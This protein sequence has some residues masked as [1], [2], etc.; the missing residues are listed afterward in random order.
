MCLQVDQTGELILSSCI[1]PIAMNSGL[2]IFKFNSNGQLYSPILDKC[3][4]V[5]SSNDIID[6]TNNGMGELVMMGDCTEYLDK[7]GSI[8]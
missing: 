6:S 5:K 7:G 2:D 8:W 4:V 3:V 1:I